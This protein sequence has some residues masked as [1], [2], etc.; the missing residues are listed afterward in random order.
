M[1]RLLLL[2][3]VPGL[4]I[5]LGACERPFVDVARP[6]ARV[7]APDLSEVQTEDT[8]VL[9]VE[10]SSFRT[11]DRVEVNGTPMAFAGTEN[12]WMA[13]VALLR[14]LNR[15]V[16]T[17]HDT[18]GTVAMDTTWAVYLPFRFAP[19]GPSLPEPRGG[20]TLT[21]LP[22]GTLLAAGG[23]PDVRAEARRDAFILP[24]GGRAFSMI[25]APMLAART[26]HT[27]TP[28][29]D[30][31]VLFV[32]G[33]STEDLAAVRDLVETVE[34]FDPATQRFEVLPVVGQ[35]IRRAYHTALLRTAGDAL[36]LDLFGGR[37]DIRYEPTPRLGTRDDLRT[38]Q[39]FPDSLVALNS[40]RSAPFLP[41]ALWGHTLSSLAFFGPDLQGQYLVEGTFFDAG[42]VDSVGYVVDYSRPPELFFRG[43]PAL[44]SP[45]IRHAAVPVADL[46]GFFGGY[47]GTPTSALAR[48]EF[49]SPTAR[50]FFRLPQPER[51][52]KRFGHAATNLSAQRI[53]LVGGFAPD[54]TAFTAAELFE[55]GTMN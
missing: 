3:V 42:V 32:G 36:L 29:P 41:A 31:R 10:A 27:A 55:T 53:L 6:D 4:A 7:V 44:P 20:H 25:P 13:E 16:L 30:G 51:S 50:R 12:R 2:V 11:I 52:I 23:A 47:Q 14:G 24:P 18:G 34:V 9:E 46:L 15:L 33:S 8:I 17:T 48:T 26:G 54:G 1:R 43:A 35:P 19:T 21:F 49:Y 22:D 45:R 28:L 37:G 40:L 5:A 39:V 38:F